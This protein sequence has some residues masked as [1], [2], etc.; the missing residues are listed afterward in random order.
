MYIHKDF[1]KCAELCDDDF[2]KDIFLNCARGRFPKNA[3]YDPK[4]RTIKVYIDDGKSANYHTSILPPAGEEDIEKLY[5]TC[6]NFFQ[7]KLSLSSYLSKNFSSDYITEIKDRWVQK[8][9]GEWKVRSSKTKQSDIYIYVNSLNI[10][11]KVGKQLTALLFIGLFTKQITEDDIIINS[12]GSI[13][14]IK[15]IGFDEG[16]NMYYL[17]TPI[18]PINLSS[19]QNTKTQ[20]FLDFV[21]KNL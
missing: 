5:E 20:K 7:N 16:T 14:K 1:L 8:K 11:E 19:A 9:R 6:L 15:S 3:K 10:S 17:T 2:W 4:N 13:S 18:T 12:E 21:K